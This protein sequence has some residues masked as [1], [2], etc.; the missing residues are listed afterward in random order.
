MQVMLNENVR[1]DALNAALDPLLGL[2]HKNVLLIMQTSA[3]ENGYLIAMEHIGK[4]LFL[5]QTYCAVNIFRLQS[6]TR[7]ICSGL[8]Y[9]H[10]RGIA[11]G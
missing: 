5:L 8:E 6:L 11:H 4:P 2:N 10:S 3:S 1:L 9:L 7:Q